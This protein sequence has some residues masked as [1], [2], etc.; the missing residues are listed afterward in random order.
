MLFFVSF[1]ALQHFD[2]F[3]QQKYPRYVHR[4]IEKSDYF[5]LLCVPDQFKND[6]TKRLYKGI[7]WVV[8]LINDRKDM[9]E[10]FYYPYADLYD[11]KDDTDWGGYEIHFVFCPIKSN[12]SELRLLT[13]EISKRSGTQYK[14]YSSDYAV[15]FRLSEDNKIS[16]FEEFR[17]GFAWDLSF[18]SVW[19]DKK[20]HA[21]R[22]YFRNDLS[23]G[24]EAI[25][26]ELDR[27]QAAKKEMYIASGTNNLTA[28]DWEKLNKPSR[29]GDFK[30]GAF[31]KRDKKR[32]DIKIPDKCKDANMYAYIV[33]TLKYLDQSCAGIAKGEPGPVI[34]NPLFEIEER[35]ACLVEFYFLE[36]YISDVFV[37]YG[38]MMAYFTFDSDNNLRRY[39]V[40]NLFPAF[41]TDVDTKY[42]EKHRRQYYIWEHGNELRFH[43]NG[44]LATFRNIDNNHLFGPQVEWNDKGEVISDV[45]LDIPK[46]WK[47]S[48]QKT[49]NPIKK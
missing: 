48:P 25:W 38:G 28:E 37:D 44:Y 1:F 41:P 8:D 16:K 23:G 2:C 3:A 5:K 30:K 12:D 33:K 15:L 26:Q 32:V 9:R 35:M 14:T 47:D 46:K 43:A 49:D 21:Y 24:L 31:F 11:E 4:T 40:G 10:L 36:D 45:I 29:V 20:E 18:Y 17:K 13:G 39:M 34:E 27:L 7:D 42:P 22:Y 19:K 6:D